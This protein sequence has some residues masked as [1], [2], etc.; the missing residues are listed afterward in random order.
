MST[1]VES[2][3]INGM[4][5][6]PQADED[7]AQYDLAKSEAT[8][9]AMS[10]WTPKHLVGRDKNETIATCLGL[11]TMAKKWNMSPSM[12]AGETYSVHGKIG[13][14]GKLYAA[15]ANAHGGLVGGLRTIYSGKGESLAAVIFGAD[16]PLTD[17]EK[18]LLKKLVRTGDSDAATDLELNNVKAIRV[19]LAQCKTDQAMWKA[20]PEQKLFYTGSTKWCRKFMPDLVL[21]AISV[22]DLERIEYVTRPDNVDESRT[23]AL[24]N[25]ISGLIGEAKAND[26]APSPTTAEVNATSDGK[27]FSEGPV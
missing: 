4:I 23:E 9:L 20:D 12:V 19:L 26:E 16:H 1:V 10:T 2:K 8:A 21:G 24:S 17:E 14:Q 18:E 7:R 22:E 25:R 6:A 27:L 11:V 15:L 3:P 5:Y 13:F